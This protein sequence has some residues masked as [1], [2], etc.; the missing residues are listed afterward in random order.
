MAWYKGLLDMFNPPKR[1][2]LP[3]QFRRPP[4]WM[5]R[6]LDPFQPDMGDNNVV[7]TASTEVEG[8]EF[9]YPTLRQN[10]D[11]TLRPSGLLESMENRD[12]LEFDSPDEATAYSKAFS[13]L[14]DTARKTYPGLSPEATEF[15]REY[16]KKMYQDGEKETRKWF[17]AAFDKLTPADR[18]NINKYYVRIYQ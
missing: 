4:L 11:L 3:G 5:Q 15:V 1:R 18:I 9:L 8:K 14:L 12:Y 7:H 10:E 2:R 13:G 17:P 16:R 6:S